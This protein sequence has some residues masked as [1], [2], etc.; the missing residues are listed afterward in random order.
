MRSYNFGVKIQSLRIFKH[1]DARSEVSFKRRDEQMYL[2][3]GQ[4]NIHRFCCLHIMIIPVEGK[5]PKKR[6]DKNGEGDKREAAKRKPASE[7]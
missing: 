2:F 3:F 7:V 5:R 6:G 1:C 4:Y